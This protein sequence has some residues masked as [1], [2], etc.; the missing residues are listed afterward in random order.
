MNPEKVRKILEERPARKKLA[1]AIE[2]ELRLEVHSRKEVSNGH[3]PALDRYLAYLRSGL[4]KKVYHKVVSQIRLPF[5]TVALVDEIYQALE[6]VFRAKNQVITH[7]ISDERFD[8]MVKDYFAKYYGDKFWRM[9]FEK[10]KY[11]VNSA[12]YVDFPEEQEGQYPEPRVHFIRAK[13][14]I[15][16]EGEDELEHLAFMTDDPKKRYYIIDENAYMV[17]D[18]NMSMVM[19]VSH[20]FGRC[21]ARWMWTDTLDAECRYLKANELSVQLGNLDRAQKKILLNSYLDDHSSA[22]IMWVYERKCEYQNDYSRCEEGV[23]ISLDDG[24]PIFSA[25]DVHSLQ[26]CPLCNEK[27][28]TGPGSII[29]VDIPEKG[30]QSLAPPAG[31]ILPDV[32]SLQH[33]DKKADTMLREIYEACVGSNFDIMEKAQ[34]NEDQV[35][36]S[37]ESRQQVLEKFKLNFEKAMEWVFTTV[38]FGMIGNS[39]RGANVDLGDE[40]YLVPT[41]MLKKNYEDT[42]Q[43]DEGLPM[44]DALHKEY[45]QSKYKNNPAQLER[46]KILT[47]IDPAIHAT[48]ERLI[49]MRESG[50][51]TDTEFA[52]KL[53]MWRYIREWELENGPMEAFM[54]PLEF[55]ARVKLIKEQIFS[56]IQISNNGNQNGNEPGTI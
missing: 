25:T 51:I 22:P 10:S 49:S 6:K 23:L 14:I 32:A 35:R 15:S 55:P 43:K 46:Q 38:G 29:E 16:F 18:E 52:F 50:V 39:Y 37:Y 40:F 41:S 56:L 33:N 26:E 8:S 19:N 34:V 3:Y 1:K 27:S 30:E 28:L 47:A 42:I 36:A 2:H 24:V 4:H 44:A 21:P 11:Q 31:L 54:I 7:D 12:M 45:I 48:K 53:N 17:F 13:D 9:F 20:N 5:E